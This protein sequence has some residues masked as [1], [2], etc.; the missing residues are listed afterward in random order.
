MESGR[1]PEKGPGEYQERVEFGRVSEMWNPGECR[2]CGIRASTGKG[3]I[4]EC[5][6]KVESGQVPEMWNL[7]KYRKW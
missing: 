4:R 6:G 5:A 3:R 2:K 1:V 7:G